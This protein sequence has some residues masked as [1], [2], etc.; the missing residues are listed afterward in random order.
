MASPKDSDRLP[1]DPAF[2]AI[3]SFPRMIA[4][5]LRGYAVKPNGP[6]DPRTIAALDFRTLRKLPAEWVTPGFRKRLG[7]QAW[8]VRFRWTQD[9]EDPGGY[10][11]I[12]VEFQSS[13]DRGMALRMA[14][15]TMQLLAELETTG[16]VPGGRAVS[17]GLPDRHPQWAAALDRLYDAARPDSEAEAAGGRRGAPQGC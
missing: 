6:L 17:A 14:G 5:A 3:Y 7:D 8:Q 13:V 12:L 10:L 16:K 9:R 2:K 1:S 4:D 15:Y 11:L